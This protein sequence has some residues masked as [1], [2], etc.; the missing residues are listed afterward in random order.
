MICFLFLFVFLGWK[1]NEIRKESRQLNSN[2]SLET[3]LVLLERENVESSLARYESFLKENKKELLRNQS[4]QKA[5]VDIVT[6]LK[7]LRETLNQ[8]EFC[9]TFDA[10]EQKKMVLKDTA[11]FY[12]LGIFILFFMSSYMFTGLIKV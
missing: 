1:A 8:S 6:R 11:N 9:K 12:L 7:E 2:L 4:Y 5:F 10:N 3:R